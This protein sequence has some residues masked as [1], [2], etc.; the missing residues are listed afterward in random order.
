MFGLGQPSD[1]SPPL[2][3]IVHFESQL[4]CHVFGGLGDQ[5]VQTRFDL[6]HFRS[7]GFNVQNEALKFYLEMLVNVKK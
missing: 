5:I 2:V 4:P 1:V 6:L 7:Q 3:Q